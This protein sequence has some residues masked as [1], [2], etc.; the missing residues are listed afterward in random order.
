MTL[1]LAP[2]IAHIIAGVP[3]P[4]ILRNP[5]PNWNAR[6]CH[7]N[8]TSILW[9]Y[10]V[11]TDRRA[12]ARA[13]TAL[14]M[15]ATNAEFWTGT[16]WDGSEAMITR[17]RPICI[18]FAKH[19]RISFVSAS[20]AKTVVITFQGIQACYALVSGANGGYGLTSGIQT[21]FFPLAICS[22]LRLPAALWL[23]E[24]YGYASGDWPE[25]SM[26]DPSATSTNAFTAAIAR[27]GEGTE[28]GLSQ[29]SMGANPSDPAV[30]E[31]IGSPTGLSPVRFLE[32]ERSTL[33]ELFY[34]T[35]GC[36]GV[37]T[38]IFFLTLIL[39]LWVLDLLYFR[40]STELI[41][42]ATN[43]SVNIF[44]CFLLS[45]TFIVM[46]AYILKG[47]STTTII[48]C[49]SSTWYKVYTYLLFMFTLILLIVSALETQRTPCG[50]YTTYSTALIIE[51]GWIKEIC[52]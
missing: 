43:L 49:I 48:P 5:P 9:R 13:W 22:L 1:C 29:A 45:V 11:I 10:F 27:N 32:D 18:R 26:S 37:T 15:A 6:I 12:R 30:Q 19:S 52:P 17:S 14:D 20:A 38:R 40:P 39:A 24:E 3:E 28:R 4:V 33:H 31:H 35:R 44:Y 7:Y 21:I 25:D 34:P 50:Q 36:R 23:S 16:Q 41:W 51:K 8:P 42:T 47:E 2:L 46:S